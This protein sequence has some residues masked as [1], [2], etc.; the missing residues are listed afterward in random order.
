MLFHPFLFNVAPDV[1]KI[2][3]IETGDD[4]FNV[5][6]TPTDEDKKEDGKPNNPGT[7]FAL[8]YKQKGKKNEKYTSSA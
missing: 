7:D 5:S 8:E 1:P 4:F 3:K 6:W 2:S